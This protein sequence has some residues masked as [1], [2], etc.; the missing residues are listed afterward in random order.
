[1]SCSANRLHPSHPLSQPFGFSS[2]PSRS[3]SPVCSDNYPHTYT[4]EDRLTSSKVS[5]WKGSVDL[6]LLFPK[7]IQS[8][9]YILWDRPSRRQ[10]KVHVS[11]CIT[12]STLEAFNPSS[13][14]PRVPQY[15]S[16]LPQ[17]RG[18][19][20]LRYFAH[21]PPFIALSHHRTILSR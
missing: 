8:V 16:T 20:L 7:C 6:V 2:C 4:L 13:P 11:T 3:Y 9:Y 15:H 5:R 18:L 17:Y 12:R 21:P 10:G 19:P 1:M 14:V